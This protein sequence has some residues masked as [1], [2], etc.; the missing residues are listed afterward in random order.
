VEPEG[1]AMNEPRFIVAARDDNETD[2]AAMV[3]TMVN[4]KLFAPSIKAMESLL[5]KLKIME[6]GRNGS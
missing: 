5:E 1:E 2:L 3:E 4:G 6:R